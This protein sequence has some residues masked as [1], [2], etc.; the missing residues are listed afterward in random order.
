MNLTGL[1]VHHNAYL[2]GLGIL[3]SKQDLGAY[4]AKVRRE[5]PAP[6]CPFKNCRFVVRWSRSNPLNHRFKCQCCLRTFS[7]ST[8]SLFHY[9]HKPVEFM[10]CLLSMCLGSTP[11]VAM[12][13]R[14]CISPG[15]CFQFR[16]KILA[17][18]RAYVPFRAGMPEAFGLAYSNKGNA[19]RGKEGREPLSRDLLLVGYGP[20]GEEYGQSHVPKGSAR[21]GG[22]LRPKA[23][24]LKA[25]LAGAFRGVSSRY[26]CNYLVWRTVLGS[27]GLL[28]EFFV[29]VLAGNET[30]SRYFQRREADIG[31][32][33]VI[34]QGPAG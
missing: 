22:S 32:C 30:R 14:L 23:L 17:S 6:R 18:L 1:S 8:G 4:L 5:R 26:L 27:V 7:E 9:L 13:E 21:A 31:A 34:F 33:R 20:G 16:H 25:W 29:D 12:S 15:A 19:G 10:E 11:I 3:K 2:R 24:G 28:A